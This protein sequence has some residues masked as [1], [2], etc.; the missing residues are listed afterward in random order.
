MSFSN[1]DD[2]SVV[3]PTFNRPQL[4]TRA[5]RSVLKQTLEPVEI[6]VVIDGP[7]PNTVEEL[8]KI[9]N[10]RVKL[11]E[12]QVKMGPAGARNAGIRA[13]RGTWIA[14][15]DD[16]DEWLSRKLEFQL[17]A[18]K[19][20]SAL[21]PVVF[22]RFMACR[23]KGEFIWPSRLPSSSEPISE[24]LFCRRSLFQGEGLMLPSAL[25]TKK[26]LFFTIPFDEK[27][28]RHE[29]WDWI[30]KVDSLDTVV[31]KFIPQAMTVYHEDRGRESESKT[32]KWR[33]SLDWLRS[34]PRLITP[35]AYACFI[36]TIVAPQA[37]KKHEWKAF[38]PLLKE[39]A[40][41]RGAKIK[42]YLLY[43][44]MW[45]LSADTREKIRA[46]F[47]RNYR[48]NSRLIKNRD[49]NEAWNGNSEKR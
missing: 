14:L 25:F 24:Y 30:L 43:F 41:I 5:V 46:V 21:Y 27:A 45:F 22:C 23:S 42:D 28:P 12:L 29:D 10:P 17:S 18:A 37:A 8:Q 47:T 33:D 49:N 9:E 36:T 13:A 7:D 2:I 11:I 6:I 4:V 16:D 39:V 40:P 26:E 15:L 19:R 48:K 31:F 1:Q 34:V 44:V 20:S 3:I 32:N 38:W 35:R